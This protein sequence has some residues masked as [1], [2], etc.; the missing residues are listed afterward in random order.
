MSAS[1]FT[2]R[3][4]RLIGVVLLAACAAGSAMA[5]PAHAADPLTYANLIASPEQTAGTLRTFLALTALSL[6][7][8]A[9][10][11]MT[12]FV[13]ITIVLSML[14]HA[15]GLQDS[16][17]NMV[18]ISLALF[19]TAFSMQ[20]TLQKINDEAVT[21]FMENRLNVGMTVQ[22]AVVPLKAFMIRQT[23]E[24]DLALMVEIS[25]APM[26]TAEA[27]VSLVQLVPAFMLS[28]LQAA[29]QIGF[30]LFLPFLLVDLVVS[31]VLMSLGMMMVPPATISI[32]VKIL[33]FVLID[34]W[35]LVIRSL[36]GTI[37]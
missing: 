37:H 27:E 22:R 14:R 13:R 23:R 30:V 17:P 6:V 12:S 19:L 24:A 1:A 3:V 11:C 26:P 36:L 33:L 5:A 35:N 8:M 25:G 28:E 7:P 34:G 20:P 10:I 9:L 29:F 16:P 31:G 21:P 15:I 18:L 4:A 32:P 2:R